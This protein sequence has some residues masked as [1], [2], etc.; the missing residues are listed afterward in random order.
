MTVRPAPIRF[1]DLADPVFP[2][3]SRPIRE[4]LAGYGTTLDLTAESMLTAATERTGL[5]DWGA[6]DFKSVCRSCAP[7]CAKRPTSP[8]PA[9]A[10]SSSRWWAT[11]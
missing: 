8:T 11:W 4:G 10:S 7:R 1:T 9:G 6:T 5:T 3:A 2:E